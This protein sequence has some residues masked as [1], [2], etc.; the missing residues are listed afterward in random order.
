MIKMP[1]L[2][3][4]FPL[5]TDGDIA[6]IN[7]NS[8]RRQSWS[9]FW[10]D[11]QRPGIAE[12]IVEQERLMAQ[13]VGDLSAY[14][15]LQ[16][17]VDHLDHMSGES[18]RTALIKAQVASMGHRFAE[19]REYLAQ[20]ESQGAQPADVARLALNIDQACGTRL[21]TVLETRHRM[22]AESGRLEDLVPLGALLADLRE[23]DEADRLYDCA[24]KV[25]ADVSPFA[26]AWVCFQRGVLWGELVPEPESNRA[27]L[28]YRQAIEYLPCYVKARVHLSE[29]YLNSGDA[30]NAESL[31]V[32]VISSGDPE[33]SW[34]LADVMV[35]SGEVAEAEA[36]LRTAESGF[37]SLLDKYMLAFA[38]HGAEFF[39]G[40]GNDPQRAFELAKI[41]LMNRPTL[42]AFEQAYK[43]AIGAEQTV[44]ASELRV[45]AAK[46]WGGTP[47]FG[48][49]I[50]AAKSG[51]VN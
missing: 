51:D 14:E 10:E 11:P 22:A 50:L 41:N 27:A 2:E 47:A 3:M 32:P 17:L 37:E 34:R 12:Q 15:R 29:I 25:Y 8:S 19:A 40:S 35:A 5:V 6:V 30:A 1:S 13:Y 26:A 33:V 23:F 45:A 39:S 24:L 20:A 44:A 18:S 9:R 16:A 7:L 49:S 48:R 4:D 21:E 46:S 31:L 42:R 28:W 36:H 38:D 43:T